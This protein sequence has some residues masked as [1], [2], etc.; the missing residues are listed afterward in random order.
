LNSTRVA[1]RI[2][3]P[4]FRYLL[5]KFGMD[6]VSALRNSCGSWRIVMVDLRTKHGFTLIELL[7]VVAI[8]GVLAAIAIPQFNFYRTKAFDAAAVSD[9]KS[10]RTQMEAHQ[11]DY[12]SYPAF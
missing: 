7:V 9:L 10:F 6:D 5:V 11:A 3:L 12:Q 1:L 2:H 8:I 4:S